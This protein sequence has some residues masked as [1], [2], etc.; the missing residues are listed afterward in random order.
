[1]REHKEGYCDICGVKYLYD[2]EEW[3]D[4]YLEIQGHKKCLDSVK[5][6]YQRIVKDMNKI[7]FSALG[8]N[9]DL[10]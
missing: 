5:L 7:I 9:H 3:T 8:V 10:V 2:K 6:V 1:M 4:P